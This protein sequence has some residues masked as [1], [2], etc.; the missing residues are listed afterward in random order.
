M[1][2]QDVIHAIESKRCDQHELA[3]KYAQ[4]MIDSGMERPKTVN[5]V[6]IERWSYAGLFNVKKLA[7]FAIKAV[8]TIR[9]QPS[10]KMEPLEDS[11]D[12]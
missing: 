1:T 11:T 8:G 5:R 6:I 12:G 3:L 2:E 10:A 4:W 9:S 7:W